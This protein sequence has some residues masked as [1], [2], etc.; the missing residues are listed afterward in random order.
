MEFVGDA[1]ALDKSM[2]DYREIASGYHI[3]AHRWT[4][5]DA[6]RERSVILSFE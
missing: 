2:A 5:A 4:N 1:G 6:T 3:R